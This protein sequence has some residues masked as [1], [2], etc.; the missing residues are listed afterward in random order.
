MP[1]E[2]KWKGTT[3]TQ[4]SSGLRFNNPTF[5]NNHFGAR[6]LKIYRR[7][8]A[9]VSVPNCKSQRLEDFVIPGGTIR[10]PQTT[11]GIVSTTEY[12]N[13]D[14]LCVSTNCSVIQSPAAN[15]RRRVRSS[16]MIKNKD[17]YCT[18][19]SQYLSSRSLSFSQNQYFHVQTGSSTVKPGSALATKNIYSSNGANHCPK[20]YIGTDTSFSYKWID[21][22]SNTVDVSAGY[23]NIDDFNALLYLKMTKNNH[24]FVEKVNFTKVMVFKFVYDNDLNVIQ[25]QSRAV[26]STTFAPVNYDKPGGAT[27]FISTST[28][29]A[30]NVSIVIANS[31]ITSGLGFTAG[32]YPP[33][34]TSIPAADK[35]IN[36]SFTPG[37]RPNYV[38]IYYK[39]SNSQFGVQGAVSSSDRILRKKYDTI[40]TVG[41]SFRTAYGPQTAD[42]MAYGVSDY[43]YTIKDKIG[44]EAKKIP[45]FSEYS[46]I[47]KVCRSKRIS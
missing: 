3:F 20:Y 16:G 37:M 43:G 25:I 12:V 4:L 23:Y 9:N 39:P 11:G 32:T 28:T 22:S 40:T 36:G 47:M 41:G 38:P 29:D 31:Q 30:S 44:V 45:T 18:N 34:Q 46:N 2:I 10:T 1:E 13:R 27:W 17:T 42:A 35:N 26:N 21:T 6:P 14:S 8:I 33:S 5:T 19:S 24:Y 7:E 15:A